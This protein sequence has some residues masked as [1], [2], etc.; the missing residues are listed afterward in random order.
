MGGKWPCLT[1]GFIL[2][3]FHSWLYPREALAS[4]ASPGSGGGTSLVRM[5]PEKNLRPQDEY[6]SGSRLSNSPPGNKGLQRGLQEGRKA[7]RPPCW[8]SATYGPAWGSVTEK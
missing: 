5:W 8:F 6:T 4:G 3:Y 2:F 1:H 7:V